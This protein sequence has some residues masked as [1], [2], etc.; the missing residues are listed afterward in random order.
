MNDKFFTKIRSWSDKFK[1]DG[2]LPT[3]MEIAKLGPHPIEKL[4]AC[5]LSP[6]GHHAKEEDSQ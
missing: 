3:P 4:R 1:Q 5:D 6:V 2:S